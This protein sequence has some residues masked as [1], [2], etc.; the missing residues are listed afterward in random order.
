MAQAAL[1]SLRE[2]SDRAVAAMTVLQDKL[3]GGHSMTMPQPPESAYRRYV[4]KWLP[5]LRARTT[6][7][8]RINNILRQKWDDPRLHKE[9]CFFEMQYAMDKAQYDEKMREIRLSGSAVTS[10]SALECGP[11]PAPQPKPGVPVDVRPSH[12]PSDSQNVRVIYIGP[13]RELWN[14]SMSRTPKYM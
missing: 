9:R 8:K 6:D 4:K 5:V 12:S 13:R 11:A 14:A 1:E 3:S 2:A 10:N 7:A